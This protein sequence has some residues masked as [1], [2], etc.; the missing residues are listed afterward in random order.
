MQSAPK[1]TPECKRLENIV[2][3]GLKAN[4][5]DAQ[6][7][8]NARVALKRLRKKRCTKSLEY[9]M[10]VSGNSTPFDTFGHEICQKARQYL[11]ELS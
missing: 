11:S 9:I 4:P 8:E 6:S 3:K 7:R 1:T 2:I 10:E 5:F